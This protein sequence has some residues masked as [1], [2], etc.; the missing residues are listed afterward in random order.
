MSVYVS[1]RVA[2]Q[3]LAALAEKARGQIS[4]ARRILVQMDEPVTTRSSGMGMALAR[5]ANIVEQTSHLHASGRE[6]TLMAGGATAMGRQLFAGETFSGHPR[7]LPIPSRP[8]DMV[9][10]YPT[11]VRG[12]SD[13]D[14]AAVGSHS[15][16]TVYD[17]MFKVYGIKCGQ[18]QTSP[19]NVDSTNTMSMISGLNQVRAVPLLVSGVRG[20]TEEASVDGLPMS[21]PDCAAAVLAVKMNVDLVVFL[22]QAGGAYTADPAEA[23]A[24]IVPLVNKDSTEGLVIHS[25]L[26]SKLT[27]AKYAM[28]NGVPAVI[29][30]GFAW[31]SILDVVEGKDAG[32]IFM[33][34]N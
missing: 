19:S 18:I 13:Q 5:T 7:E 22:S 30:D 3:R 15:M 23:D 9:E 28:A 10:P 27:A 33:D 32:T 6:I 21:S 4:G 8:I 34:I 31:R 25:G 16:M 12:C 14:L 29:V 11:V 2:G 17:T 20:G 24:Q 26:E 1:S